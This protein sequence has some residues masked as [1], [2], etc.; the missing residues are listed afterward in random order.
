M[1]IG[2][3][4]CDHYRGQSTYQSFSGADSFSSYSQSQRGQLPPYVQ[5][6][7]KISTTYR[8]EPLNGRRPFH[9]SVRSTKRVESTT[10]PAASDPCAPL[11]GFK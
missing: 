4:E 2:A 8:Q 11:R 5:E 10:G 1:A 6:G 3:N 7:L 9:A